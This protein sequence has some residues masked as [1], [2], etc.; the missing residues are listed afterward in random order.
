[1]SAKMISQNI[2]KNGTHPVWRVPSAVSSIP[3]LVVR[4][5]LTDTKE[6][7]I[8]AEGNIV[9]M[10]VCGPTVYSVSH[11][12]HARTFL[13]FDILRRILEKYFRYNVLYQLNITD[14]DDKIIL[15]ARKN[16][17]LKQYKAE[18]HP[19]VSVKQTILALASAEEQKLLSKKESM[20]SD[21]PTENSREFAEYDT[22]LKQLELKIE[23]LNQAQERLA[24]ERFSSVDDLIDVG[25]DL[26][27]NALDAEKGHTISDKAVFESHSRYYEEEFLKD[28]KD[29]SVREPDVLTRVTEYVP[30]IVTFVE[31]IISNGFAYESNGSVYFNT[32]KF[33]D[34]HDYPKLVPHAG[35]GAT[36]AEIAEGEGAL[37]GAAD[38]K[39]HRNDFALWKKSKPG[40]PRWDSPWGEGR[41]GWHIECSVM[42]TAIHGP[43]LDIH[44]GGV[45][46]KFPH[47]DNEIAQTE[48]HFESDQWVNYFLHAGHLHIKGLKMAKSLKN[49]I[50]IRQALEKFTAKQIRIMFLLQQWD[51]PVNFSDQTLNEARDK[52]NRINSFFARVDQIGRNFPVATSPQKWD[53]LDQSLAENILL[54]QEKVHAALC[55]NFDTPAAMEAVEKCIGAVNQ[56]LIEQTVPKYPVLLRA[57]DFV[58]GIL[59][60]FGVVD[61]TVS[62]ATADVEKLNQIVSQYVSTRDRI[63]EIAS[64]TRNPDLLKLSDA[65]RDDVFVNLGIKVVDGIKATD[66]WSLVNPE[67]LRRELEIRQQERKAKELAKL[68]NKRNNLEKELSKW[69]RH[70]TGLSEREILFSE[71][72]VFDQDGVPDDVTASKKKSLKKDLEK[73]KKERSDFEAKGGRQY[74]EKLEVDLQALLEQISAMNIYRDE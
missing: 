39:L 1:M 60:V 9:R 58:S 35:S 48:A 6:P 19:M 33:R 68:E 43:V 64:E 40:E 31:K 16:E 21:K 18:S 30:E 25:K 27:M 52:E 28:C 72:T 46:L 37:A 42:A 63:R 61:E 57:K 66:T 2:V 15:T 12:G 29:L 14:I 41:P 17:L 44:G 45:D 26:L 47:H 36:D 5:S 38:E 59:S 11:M 23:Q 24:T 22:Q 69:S 7:L 8:P 73:F 55:D 51:R 54:A 10:Y 3:S 71:F 56:Y 74:Y 50:T 70:I 4:N 49:F 20:L 53:P 13:C 65:L 32:Q 67:E 34:V 62:S